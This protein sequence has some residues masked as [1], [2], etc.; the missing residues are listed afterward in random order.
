M[1]THGYDWERFWIHFVFGA[2]IGGVLGG[3]SWLQNWH[4]G[5]SPWLWIGSFS[6]VIAF[7][8]GL[9]GDRFWEWF[10]RNLRWW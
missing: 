5:L 1:A 8:G 10:L 4:Q 6:F 9:L 7:L 2:V 3:I